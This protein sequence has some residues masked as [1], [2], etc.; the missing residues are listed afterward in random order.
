METP[1]FRFF[2]S[3]LC[4]SVVIVTVE[5]ARS[6]IIITANWRNSMPLGKGTAST[7]LD[8]FHMPSEPSTRLAVEQ[9]MLR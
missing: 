2:T 8:Y 5:C 1:V 6:S 7:D 3:A 9:K 4:K